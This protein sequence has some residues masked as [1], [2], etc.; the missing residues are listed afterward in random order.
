MQFAHYSL[1]ILSRL[2]SNNIKRTDYNN[3]IKADPNG[4]SFEKVIRK[5]IPILAVQ[6]IKIG[7]T[8]RYSIRIKHVYGIDIPVKN[9]T[10]KLL[11]GKMRKKCMMT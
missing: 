10:H 4:I 11:S 1:S 9:K 3:K 5:T 8:F 2:H 6:K 7:S